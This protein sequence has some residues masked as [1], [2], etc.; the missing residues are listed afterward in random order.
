MILKGAR[1]RGAARSGC[2]PPRDE[3]IQRCIVP[4][5]FKK[6]DGITT[7]IAFGILQLRANLGATLAEPDER[8]R[9]SCQSMPARSGAGAG[10]FGWVEVM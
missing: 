3:A 8:H 1:R 2:P 9:G 4:Q 5:V 7:A 6:T 10:S